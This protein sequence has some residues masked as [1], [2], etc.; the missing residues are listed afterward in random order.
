MDYHSKS[1]KEFFDERLNHKIG[2]KLKSGQDK[3]E[4]MD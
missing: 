1:W 3:V 4:L 2:L